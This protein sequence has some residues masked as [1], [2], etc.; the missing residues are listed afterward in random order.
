MTK[1][2]RRATD[3]EMTP[4]SSRGNEAYES[5][6]RFLQTV[7][8]DRARSANS[9]A[10]P[11]GARF[12]GDVM[13]TGVVAA[14]ESAAFKE[15]IGFMARNHV[16][17]VPVIDSKRRVLGVVSE[18]DLLAHL[19]LV[20]PRLPR[21][22]V[23][24]TWGERARKIHG[25]T[26]AELMTSPA[27]V[28]VPDMTISSAAWLAARTRVKRL[29]VVDK[30]GELVGIVS[31]GDLLKP[32]LRPD[33]EIHADIV[34]NVLHGAYLLD[35]DQLLVA[36]TEGVVTLRGHLRSRTLAEDILASIHNVTGVIDVHAQGVSSDAD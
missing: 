27:V 11:S 24:H 10:P 18:A 4:A 14:H 22:F 20:G 35:R 12:V 36:V 7:L 2:V 19:A 28:A 26:A 1:A 3:R 17:G 21:G 6:L 29:P 31:R 15:I 16:S 9:P 8:H 25:R 5:T 13:T 23:M 34:E 30:T 32:Y 33:A